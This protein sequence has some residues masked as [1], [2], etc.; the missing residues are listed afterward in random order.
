MKVQVQCS[1]CMVRMDH[2]IDVDRFPRASMFCGRCA[3][4]MFAPV[5]LSASSSHM[6]KAKKGQ[7]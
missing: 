2:F 7:K 3:R 4:V 1:K 5:R 6:V